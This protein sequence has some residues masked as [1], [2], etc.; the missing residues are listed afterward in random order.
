MKVTNLEV[1]ENN[2]MMGE[3]KSKL[4]ERILLFLEAQWFAA[5]N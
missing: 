2:P 3:S 1:P 4:G 5:P